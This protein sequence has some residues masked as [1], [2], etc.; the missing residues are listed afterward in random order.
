MKKVFFVV[1]LLAP[2]MAHAWTQPQL[3]ALK[4]AA[5]EEPSIQA[6][7]TQGDDTC[8]ATWFNSAST[9]VVWRTHVTQDE[10]QTAVD[11]AAGVFNWSGTGGFIARSQGERDAWRTMFAPGYVNP[12]LDNVRAAFADIFSGAGAG[13]VANRNHLAALSKRAA[14][15]AEKVL[16]TGTGSDAS[17]GTLTFEG[18]IDAALVAQ[19]LRG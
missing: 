3:T 2:L 12:A 13:A 17:P 15:Q 1:M 14:S 19:I 18:T 4:N 11:S 5:R 8:V 7:I 9:F 10:Y 16:A 6:C